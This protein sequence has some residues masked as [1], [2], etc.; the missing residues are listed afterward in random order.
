[1]FL[2]T[3]TS[4]QLGVLLLIVANLCLGGS[5]VIYDSMLCRHRRPG[6]A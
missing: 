5:L 1:M 6:R 2:V 4:W 3:G